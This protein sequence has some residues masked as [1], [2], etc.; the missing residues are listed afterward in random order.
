MVA[1]AVIRSDEPKVSLGYKMRPYFRT[2]NLAQ[3]VECVV[4][5]G[6]CTPGLFRPPKALLSA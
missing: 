5:V 4:A 1:R 3:N 6:D 2:K